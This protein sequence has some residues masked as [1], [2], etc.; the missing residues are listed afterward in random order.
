MCD[1]RYRVSCRDADLDRASPR[2]YIAS[3]NEA[4]AAANRLNRARRKTER[5]DTNGVEPAKGLAAGTALGG[6]TIAPSSARARY[7]SWC[8]RS[9]DLQSVASDFPVNR[10]SQLAR[11]W[12]SVE[13]STS[14]GY[15]SKTD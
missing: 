3:F 2:E 11:L 12:I 13:Q 6:R 4:Y 14:S 10:L 15:A 8:R 9:A 1:S 7:L 5:L